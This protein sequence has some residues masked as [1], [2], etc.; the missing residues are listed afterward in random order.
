[1]SGPMRTIP[2]LLALSVALGSA[3]ASAAPRSA[4]PNHRLKTGAEGKLCVDCHTEF[5]KEL[6]KPVIHSPV[7]ARDCVGCHDPH[8]SKL[9]G[10]LAGAPND[11]CA[12]CHGEVVPA[13]ATSA[14]KPAVERKCTTCH[15]PHAS[16]TKGVLVKP[17]LE[18]CGSCH[19]PLVER[20]AKVKR[21]HAPV[22]N[23]CASCHES[24]A[25]A[26]APSILKAAVPALCIGCHK[27]DK[28]IFLKQH[29]GYK[30]GAADC[31]T[32]H[33]PHGSDTKGMLF[34]R[35]HSPVARGMCSQCHEAAGST[36]QFA[37]KAKGAELCKTCHGPL[38]TK[39]LSK[40][41]V[42]SPVL[43][44]EDDCLKCHN[45]HASQQKALLERPIRDLCG[46]CHVDTMQR[47]ARAFSRHEPVRDGDCAACHDP[48]GTDGPLLLTNE[49]IVALCKGCHDWGAH[50]SHPL[51]ENFVDPRNPNLTLDC[52]SCHRSHGTEYKK[53]MPFPK[54]SD[55]CTTCHAK[56]RR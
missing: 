24:H 14:H 27:T 23:G 3:P 12:S 19:K 46:S 13:G 16:E 45:P 2:V 35:V 22:Q 47:E 55:L 52:L 51:G 42:H 29:L 15:D 18:L 41:R 25:S 44:G 10:L 31:T 40:N 30:V 32:C 36:N 49:N 9:P 33:D 6:A 50:S 56:Y 28:P 53:L 38:V 54:Q 1:M 20:I 5:A 17:T 48:H 21:K 37:T 26:K 8:A 39:M 7:R 34:D 43:G 11:I 4:K